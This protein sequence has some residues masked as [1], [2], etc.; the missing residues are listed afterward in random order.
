VCEPNA[1]A[2][3]LQLPDAAVGKMV[4]LGVERI[5]HRGAEFAEKE[6]QTGS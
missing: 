2:L 4:R 5:Y 3:P 1:L 6:N